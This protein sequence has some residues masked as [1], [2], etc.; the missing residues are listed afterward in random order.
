M[1]PVLFNNTTLSVESAKLSVIIFFSPN[2]GLN[3][4]IRNTCAVG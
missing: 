3:V 2:I 4:I 1:I